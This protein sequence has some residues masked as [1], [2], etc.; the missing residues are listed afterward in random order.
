MYVFYTR[1]HPR[2]HDTWITYFDV[3]HLDLLLLERIPCLPSAM[4][5]GAISLLPAILHLLTNAVVF[6]LLL[7]QLGVLII[8]LLLEL[9]GIVGMEFAQLLVSSS[10]YSEGIGELGDESAGELLVFGGS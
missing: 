3:F 1:Q 7:A 6:A 5:E 4:I 9:G 10:D 2:V 8:A